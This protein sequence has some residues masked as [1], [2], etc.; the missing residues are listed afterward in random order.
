M[1]A[2][3]KKAYNRAYYLKNKAN[4]AVNRRVYY[5][6]VERKDSAKKEFLKLLSELTD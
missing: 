1:E 4:I 6:E 2:A 3:A 5:L